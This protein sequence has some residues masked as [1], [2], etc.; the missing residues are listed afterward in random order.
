ME[1]KTIDLLKEINAISKIHTLQRDDIDAIMRE[2][3]QRILATFRIERMSVWLLNSSKDQLV[4]MG[5][6]DMR[7][8]SFKKNN[9]LQKQ[10]FPT[11]F[12]AIQTNEILLVENML[13]NSTTIELLEEYTKPNNVL[14]LMDIPLRIEG[15]LIGVMCF[16][17]TGE[18]ERVFTTNEQTFAMSIAI[19]FA[20]TLEARQR[21]AI[22]YQL[23]EEL[24]EKEI[25]IKEI[26]HRVKNNLAVVS[27]LMSLQA[28]KSKDEFH[29][30]L[31]N[32]SRNK[33]N[34]ISDL[35][36]NVYQRESISSLSMF[37]YLSE[38]INNL[39][40]F[41]SNTNENIQIIADIEQIS[42]PMNKALPLALII[43]EL[44][45]N[46]FKHA[47]KNSSRGNIKVKMKSFGNDLKLTVTDNGTGFETD[48]KA[49]TS[50]G[51]EI[52]KDLVEQLNGISMFKKSDGMHFEMSFPIKS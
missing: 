47:F 6:F 36:S 34:A 18:I 15:E 13:F 42:I 23:K 41:Y 48:A 27:S 21:R 1:S 20:S 33:I 50:L 3:A 2:F 7:D 10:K 38:L 16:E 9:I 30:S 51:L 46:S 4:S 25:L 52:I 39:R 12:N 8:Q 17:K 32:E 24:K 5:E 28:N 37:D 19:V 45:T 26:H 31:F 40:E 22:Q 29:R 44:V 11:Y 35:H 43:N 14:S 49:S